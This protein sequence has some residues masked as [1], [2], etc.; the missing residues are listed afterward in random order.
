MP[1]YVI[2]NTDNFDG[3]Y[4]DE[5]FVQGLPTF[6]DKAHAQAVCDAINGHE[7]RA[8]AARYYKVESEG[9]VLQPGFQ[10]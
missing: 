8:Q 6:F 2:V 10:P 7:S 3:D 9:Y 4:P 1:R 5:T